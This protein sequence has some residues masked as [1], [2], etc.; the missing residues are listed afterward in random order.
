MVQSEAFS[1]TDSLI[2]SSAGMD[3]T[4]L[5]RVFTRKSCAAP[6]GKESQELSSQHSDSLDGLDGLDAKLRL[7]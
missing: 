4:L 6:I 7:G 5:H 2:D 3:E 1:S